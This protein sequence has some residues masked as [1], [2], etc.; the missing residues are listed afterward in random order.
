MT[1]GGGIVQ[2]QDHQ[3]Y[4]RDIDDLFSITSGHLSKLMGMLQFK[5]TVAKPLFIPFYETFYDLFTQTAKSKHMQE[6]K[7]LIDEV[8][9]W[10]DYRNPID[11]E[12]VEKG[13]E[14]FARWATEMERKGI[15]TYGR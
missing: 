1:N 3:A 12:R 15:H 13:A 11:A 2:Q 10:L 9:E 5:Q 4:R 14:L 6:N 7:D 8:K